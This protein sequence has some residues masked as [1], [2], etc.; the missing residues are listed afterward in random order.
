[1]P[2]I[3]RPLCSCVAGAAQ[4]TNAMETAAFRENFVS[5]FMFSSF[6]NKDFSLGKT[7]HDELIT[8]NAND[9]SAT[10]GAHRGI[11]SVKKGTACFQVV[12]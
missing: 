2:P 10:A 7:L 1:M 11:Y 6:L 9:G 8:R 4:P 12:P 3:T 5:A